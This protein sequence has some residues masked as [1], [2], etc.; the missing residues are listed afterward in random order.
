[1]L[2]QLLL[3]R[4]ISAKRADLEKLQAARAEL[5]EK[6]KELDV[7]EAALEALVNELTDAS[8]EEEHAAV[9]AEVAAF[10]AQAAEADQ[11]EAANEEAQVSLQTEIDGLERE[12]DELNERA[13]AQAA[14][15]TAETREERN[16]HF[17]NKFLSL[18]PEQTRAFFADD[19]VKNFLG[20][21][22]SA[23]Q[24]KRAIKNAGLL[25]P[26][27]M[28]GMVREE[29]ARQSKLLPFVNLRR[30]GGTA[31]MNI[32]G[33]IPEAVWTEMCANINQI[34]LQFS[35]TEVDGY[36]VGA[37]VV[38]CNAI[39][40]DSDIALASEIVSAISTAI[41]K[42]LDKAILFGTGTK[43]PIG[44]AT[45]LA[46]SSQPAWWGTNEP[47]FTDLHTSHVKQENIFSA[48]GTAF[49][50]AL[51]ADLA[52]AKPVYSSEGLFWVMNRKT[53]LDIMARCL[54]FDASAAMVSNTNL[55]PIVGGTIVE[56]EDDELADY[57]IIGGFGGN[58]LMAERAGIQLASSTEYLFL[59]D[60][61]AFKGTAR[62]D[63]KPL[64]GEAFV[65]V[66]YANTA[67]TTAK[68][69]AEDEAN[70]VLS[71]TLPPAATVA[72]GAK[73]KLVAVTAPGDGVITWASSSTGKATVDTKGVVTGV[74]AGS[75]NTT[76]TCN[77]VT[78]TCAVTVTSA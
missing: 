16:D 27:T 54:A 36:K 57:E 31:R 15:N 43:T 52:L 40:E 2:R 42:A 23:M 13:T 34:D 66:N 17:M 12:L 14:P 38:V 41:A 39:L 29:I 44:I 35:Q 48:T 59:Q 11:A 63:G 46:A 37:A 65:I 50:Q 28:L 47:T 74:A 51:V 4:R 67:P 76:A 49:M 10:E 22:R 64:A 56:V 6:R 25:I 8:T 71:I 68:D 19:G 5:D 1:M 60:Q 20:E 53:H 58:Y 33:K 55:F 7:R 78:A 73:K 62:Y 32:M 21:V 3:T 61:T 72:A 77:G 30:V 75:A 69:F 18:N 26:D 45:R 24:E 70:E 9:D